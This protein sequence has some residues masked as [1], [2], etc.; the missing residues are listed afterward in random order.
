M[1]AALT[2][3]PATTAIGVDPLPVEDALHHPSD[4]VAPADNRRWV[5]LAVLCV[6]LLIIVIDNTIVNV[7]LPSLVRQLGASVS[8][9][10]WVV[11]AYTVVF[12]GLLLLAG[13]LGDRWG[14]RRA[15]TIG[16]AVFAVAS[17]AAAFAG[18]VGQLVTA[19]AVMGGAAAFIM[20]ATLSILTN[21][22][23]DA[24][25][26]AMAIGIWSG[27]IGIGVVLGP[28]A[29]GFL[30]DH[31]W[32][33]SVFIVNVPIAVGAIVAARLLVAESRDPHAQRVDWIGGLLSVIGLVSL[34]TAIIEAP[35]HGWTSLPVVG[36]ATVSAA[37][38]AAFA[39]WER[40]V[41]HPIL[42]V[43]LFANRRFSAA[44]AAI[45][46]IFFA[47][48]GF[49]FLSTQYLQFVLG[50]LPF[51]AGL[52]TLPFAAAMMVVAPLS[53]RAVQRLG[54]K[55]VVV[56]GMLVFAAGLVLAATIA[57][58]TGYSRLGVAMV[59]LGAGL[60]LSSAPATESIMGALPRHRAGVGSAVNDT[61]RE[62][63]GALGVAIVGSITASIYRSRLT[64]DLPPQLPGPAAAA[65][66]DSLGAALQASGQ[67]GAVGAHVAA[68]A[69]EAFVAAMS[70]ASIVTAGVAALGA[71][72][73]WRYLPARGVDDSDNPDESS[74]EPIPT[75]PWYI[76]ACTCSYGYGRIC[77]CTMTASDERASCPCAT[78][79]ESRPMTSA[80]ADTTTCD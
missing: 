74:P 43:T 6:S 23:T 10:Q 62:V 18:G 29:G 65:A 78:A 80:P 34:V 77:E 25:G 69:R 2:D 61:A 17:S 55:R 48:F 58:T 37:A 36:L 79:A 75:A 76:V 38:L 39:V 35:S 44:S 28:L 46:L 31:F 12:A 47:L 3:V 16:L 21:T 54:T 1:S 53:S 13:T 20:P 70:R 67:L 42:D 52:R 72:V 15:L 8:E 14:R 56:A 22:F 32:W 68:V 30:L 57:T 24:R 19:R 71:L 66:H 64:G 26:R 33:G 60:G 5:T 27:V 9:L 49:V 73:A 63:G 40:H 7:T 4:T 45:T 59:L 41:E 51:D 11:D 50:Y